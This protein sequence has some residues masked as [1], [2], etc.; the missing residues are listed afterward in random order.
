[1][2]Y[3]TD[4]QQKMIL[5]GSNCIAKLA[6]VCFLMS[7]VLLQH[8]NIT[9]KLLISQFILLTFLFLLAWF[10]CFMDLFESFAVLNLPWNLPSCFWVPILC[11]F[12]MHWMLAT[13]NKLNHTKGHGSHGLQV[14]FSK[15]FP[16]KTLF[17]FSNVT[18]PLLTTCVSGNSL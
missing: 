11:T 1:M 3:I 9:F 5:S 4:H 14:T 7:W 15:W 17:N 8:F 10:L 16:T 18:R 2:V 12:Y 13:L 6:I